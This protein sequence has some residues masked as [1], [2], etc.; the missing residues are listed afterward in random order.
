M[1]INQANTIINQADNPD[2][3]WSGRGPEIESKNRVLANAKALRA[4]AYRHL[5]YGWGDVPLVLEESGRI[6]RTDWERTPVNEVRQ[7]IKSDLLFA[8]EHIAVRPEP[9]RITKGAIQTYLAELNLVLN[10]PARALEWANKVI[11][12]PE[13]E[14]IT[15]RYGVNLDRPGVT[16]MDMFTEG[17]ENYYQGNTE[18]LWVVQYGLDVI[19]GTST[20]NRFSRY[21]GSR[22]NDHVWYGTRALTITYDRGGRGQ[23]RQSLTK[24][25]L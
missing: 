1:L 20:N 10:N 8:E 18:E 13:Y 12:T 5:T 6:I 22:F 9:G 14:L 7:Q 4:W 2:V 16:I 25:F 23:S 3:D 17:N 24:W 15:E 19:G 11:N 21:H